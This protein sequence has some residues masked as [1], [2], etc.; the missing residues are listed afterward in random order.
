MAVLTELRRL[1]LPVTV[2]PVLFLFM[3]GSYMQYTAMQSLVY[4]KVSRPRRI[5]SI[6]SRASPADGL[7][8]TDFGDCESPVYHK[9]IAVG[10]DVY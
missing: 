6:Q 5:L 4:A 8:W 7:C 1:V 9:S 3:V 2:E 10:N